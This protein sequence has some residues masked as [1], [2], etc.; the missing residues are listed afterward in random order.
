MTQIED[1]YFLDYN[2][3]VDIAS[4]D[5]WLDKW[6][7]QLCY[8]SGDFKE[9]NLENLIHLPFEN[10]VDYFITKDTRIPTKIDTNGLEL[11]QEVKDDILNSFNILRSQIDV[12]L[13]QM[14]QLLTNEI[15]SKKL[16]F[17]EP[18]RFLLKGN[19]TTEVMQYQ[20]KNI[21]NTIKDMGYEVRF[22]LDNQYET[23]NNYR[24]TKAI[25]EYNPHVTIN[26][27]SIDNFYLNDDTFN[28]IW[29]QD[30]VD[31]LV[32]DKEIK[33]RDRDFVFHL[34]KDIEEFILEKNINST[35]QPFCLDKNVYKIY[36]D[37]KKEKKVVF[38]GSSFQSTL[39]SMKKYTI[40][41]DVYNETLNIFEQ[42]SCLTPSHY[43][44][45]MN[46]YNVP[47]RFIKFI[48]AYL[49]RDYCLE[50]LCSIKTDY[51]IEVY[52]N[53]W[54]NNTTIEPYYKGTLK[55]G[56]DISKVYNSATYG[57]CSSTYILMQRTLE[58]AFSGTIP[59]VLDVRDGKQDSCDKRTEDSLEL[60][61]L[62]NLEDILNKEPS[63]K[64]FDF[65]RDRYTFNRF[66]DSCIDKINTFK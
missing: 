55:Y 32:Q 10:I 44:H 51:K 54:E 18:L 61:T 40:F 45:L 9:N 39:D 59:L 7:K 28:F 30:Q 34:T 24:I 5:K 57:F 25:F 31:L 2:T 12:K 47:K 60:F 65:I 20:S 29:F 37:I 15:K 66:I 16:N 27:N 11:S 17:N 22:E 58:C 4:Q 1:T 21:A 49:T 3:A 53:G 13:E 8:Y 42:K 33:L 41:Q 62:N 35:F 14:G 19:K 36:N 23:I 64:D 52:G 26:I 6:N 50:K 38:I 43:E 46:K 63:K 48:D 56:E